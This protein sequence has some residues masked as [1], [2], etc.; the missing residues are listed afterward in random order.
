LIQREE[1]EEEE[2]MR[3]MRRKRKG[4]RRDGIEGF[5]LSGLIQRKD[6]F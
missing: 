6:F 2:K 4:K 3:R 1:E 5:A